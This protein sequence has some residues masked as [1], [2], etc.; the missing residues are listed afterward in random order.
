MGLPLPQLWLLGVLYS[1]IVKSQ[2]LW[3]LCGWCRTKRIGGLGSGFCAKRV[4]LGEWSRAK[5]VSS[6]DSPDW[7]L[8]VFRASLYW[9]IR[10]CY[11]L[12]Q[13]KV[14]CT[15]GNLATKKLA[16]PAWILC[17]KMA[18]VRSSH[19]GLGKAY[20]GVAKAYNVIRYKWEGLA[21]P[22]FSPQ[23]TDC[24]MLLSLQ[25]CNPQWT[26]DP[27]SGLETFT[28]LWTTR[29]GGV[30][31]RWLNH[32]LGRVGNFSGFSA[33]WIRSK[34]HHFELG[35][36]C[37]LPFFELGLGMAPFSYG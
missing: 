26:S 8:L 7:C 30:L 20:K 9:L 13:G 29:D 15:K 22:C 18:G 35:A 14:P 10:V 36:F 4:V 37:S 25:A 32:C 31:Q 17:F 33:F 19:L 6:Q 21:V 3:V 28:R 1:S 34:L 12:F 27:G 24:F 2:T 5:R 23:A 11:Q 16:K